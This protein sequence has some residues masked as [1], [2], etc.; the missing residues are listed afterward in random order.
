M[1]NPLFILWDYAV[2]IKKENIAMLK[3]IVDE[4]NPL[5]GV[6]QIHNAS[7]PCELLPAFEHQVL[8]GY[9]ADQQ[10]AY[11]RARMNWP[12]EKVKLCSTCCPK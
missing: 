9:F 5:D 11:K 6:Y 10:L 2:M 12:T 7:M 1:N 8:I 4:K 3:F